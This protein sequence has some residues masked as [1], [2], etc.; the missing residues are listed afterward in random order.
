MYM[1]ARVF[2]VDEG[3]DMGMVKAFEDGDFGSEV[4][5]E[6]LVELAQVDRFDGHDALDA[7]RTLN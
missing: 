7:C 4:L 3:Y 5:L 2:A 1:R 6:L